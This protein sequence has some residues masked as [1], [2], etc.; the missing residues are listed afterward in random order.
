VGR[1]RTRQ[2]KHSKSKKVLIGELLLSG[3]E[4]SARIILFHQAIASRF[5]L[6]ATDYKCMDIAKYEAA[7]T[8][9]RL[10]ELT[11]LT[12]GAITAALDRLERA[13]FVQRERDAADR[14]R[15]VVRALPAA[16]EKLA[17]FFAE[18]G[19]AMTRLHEKYTSDELA[20]ILDYQA[21]CITIL[22]RQTNALGEESAKN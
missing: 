4:M 16:Q 21:G 18:L 3:R 10:A 8:A 15:V 17:P 9:G 14:R 12:T 22:E 20:L 1:S 5:G 6:N 19:G 13:G 11:G 2:A 7:V